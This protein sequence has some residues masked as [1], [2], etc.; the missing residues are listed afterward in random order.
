MTPETSAHANKPTRAIHP[1]P[2][3]HAVLNALRQM[4]GKRCKFFQEYGHTVLKRQDG[5]GQWV[6]L[7][8][9]PN[10][11]RPQAHVD[12]GCLRALARHDG[13]EIEWRQYARRFEA[14]ERR[15][16]TEEEK[17]NLQ[18]AV[19]ALNSELAENQQPAVEK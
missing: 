8:S 6:E 17:Q 9:V 16:T 5:P 18:K 19:E 14:I 4:H 1:F 7:C 10:E 11:G 12:Y 2:P 3:R 13:F 15:V